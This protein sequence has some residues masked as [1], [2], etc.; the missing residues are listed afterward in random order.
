MKFFSGS[1]AIVA[2]F[3]L[4]Y[5]EALITNAIKNW[6][7]I[8]IGGCQP[9]GCGMCGS[10]PCVV[11][12]GVISYEPDVDFLEKAKLT[13]LK[14]N[15]QKCCDRYTEKVNLNKVVIT[16]S[17]F[18]ILYP[19]S[20]VLFHNHL[21]GSRVLSGTYYFK[22]GKGSSPLIIQNK[23]SNLKLHPY[24]GRCIIFP[25][26]MTHGVKVNK[27]LERGN[28]SFNTDYREEN[29]DRKI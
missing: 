5:D 4:D 26:W 27:S 14:K 23:E 28:I 3:D 11:Q 2:S 25:A 15:F 10:K 12:K 24:N 8:P 17:W 21:A 18:N 16:N 20:E 13:N 9:D 22:V 1:G 19:G 29:N 7:K 6:K